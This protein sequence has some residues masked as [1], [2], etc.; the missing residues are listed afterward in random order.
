[1]LD[2]DL[3]TSNRVKVT[4]YGK[5]IDEKYT[6]YFFENKELTLEQVMLLDKFK[7]ILK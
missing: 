1:M 6:V 4:I 7:K 3:S 5:I 2:Y